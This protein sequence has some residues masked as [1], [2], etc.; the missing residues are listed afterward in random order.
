MN[1]LDFLKCGHHATN[2]NVLTHGCLLCEGAAKRFRA[3]ETGID[4]TLHGSAIEGRGN[5]L[6][7]IKNNSILGLLPCGHE[8]RYGILGGS[9]A[10]CSTQASQRQVA[11][12]TGIDTTLRERGERYGGFPEHARITQAIK[13]AMVDSRRWAELPDDMKEC[14]EMLA[15]KLGRILNGDPNYHD[16]WHDIIGYTKLV[17]DRLEK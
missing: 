3:D 1:N 5:M 8:V 6:N 15:N 16:S 14:L 11:Q 17:A 7:T 9:C 10:K 12:A 2:Y 4:A 13:R